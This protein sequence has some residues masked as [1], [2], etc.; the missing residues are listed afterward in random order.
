M[1]AESDP[2]RAKLK[3]TAGNTELVRV[4]RSIRRA[5]KLEG[6]VLKIGAEWLLLH[7]L[8]PDMFLDGHVAVRVSDVRSVKTLGSD[9]FAA[10]A[11]R[12]YG[13]RP[14]KLSNIELRS[15]RAVIASAGKAF[16]LVTIHIERRDPSVCYIGIPV[17]LSTKALRLREISS[18]AH[19][20]EEPTTYWLR[21]ITRV[22]VGGR[23]ERALL[24]VGGR[25]TKVKPD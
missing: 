7:V 24:A 5:D 3:A 1:K 2:I 8:N 23:Y 14:R 10:R 22:D 25:A 19:W 6:Y 11:L 17:A 18:E 4:V 9:S 16:S 13:D 12:H 15:T 20:D 21:D